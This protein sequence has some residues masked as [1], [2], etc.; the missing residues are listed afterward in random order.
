[1]LDKATLLTL[2]IANEKAIGANCTATRVARLALLAEA[3][4]AVDALTVQTEEA[5]LA[6]LALEAIV[7]PLAVHIDV[8]RAELAE[9]VLDEGTLYTA[10][11]RKSIRPQQHTRRRDDHGHHRYSE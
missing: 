9:A 4:L 5:L 11:I 2:A 10:L 3:S 7:A 1:M 6:L 8:V